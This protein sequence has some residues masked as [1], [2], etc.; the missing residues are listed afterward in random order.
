MLDPQWWA[1][2]LGQ[3]GRQRGVEA[4][5]DPDRPVNGSLP[6]VKCKIPKGMKFRKYSSVHRRAQELGHGL[7][8][9]G[10]FQVARDED[11]ARAP[12]RSVPTG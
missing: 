11:D 12:V 2:T 10:P 6:K 9:P 1:R 3:T 8:Q 7:L 4:A 5:P